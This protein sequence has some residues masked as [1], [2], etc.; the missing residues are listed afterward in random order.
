MLYRRCH[1]AVND[2]LG[3]IHMYVIR[4]FPHGI[5]SISPVVST[6]STDWHLVIQHDKLGK[7]CRKYHLRL[8]WTSAP[9]RLSLAFSEFRSRFKFARGRRFSLSGQV[10]RQW[11]AVTLD[12]GHNTQVAIVL[13][14]CPNLLILDIKVF[15]LDLTTLSNIRYFSTTFASSI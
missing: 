6:C 3:I 2:I 4:S 10:S 12:P 13:L 15:R 1:D 5:Y 8:P 14:H 9:P 7:T 11:R